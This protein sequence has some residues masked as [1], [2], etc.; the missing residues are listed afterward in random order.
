MQTIVNVLRERRDREATASATR[1][2]DHGRMALK[3]HYLGC[4]SLSGGKCTC[5]FVQAF[6]TPPPWAD[7]D[8]LRE[9]RDREDFEIQIEAARSSVAKGC[10]ATAIGE[11]NAAI[12]IL[13]R[14]G[15]RV[16]VELVH[17]DVDD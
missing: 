3:R 12:M 2:H 10:W 11:L 14:I 5:E 15:R 17:Y 8:V 9:R 7:G 13:Q 16:E 4:P 6:C 1:T